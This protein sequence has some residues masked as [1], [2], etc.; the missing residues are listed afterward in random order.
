MNRREL[1]KA[2]WT[3]QYRE[4]VH[5]VTGSSPMARALSRKWP[6]AE[7]GDRLLM[8]A[9]AVAANDRHPD[10]KRALQVLLA[11]LKEVARR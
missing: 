1:V 5:A 9:V 7:H 6:E 4:P 2:R 3:A 10:Q 11:K 8:S